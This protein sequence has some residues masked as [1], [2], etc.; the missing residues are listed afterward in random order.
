[1]SGVKSDRLCVQLRHYPF[2]GLFRHDTCIH[3]AIIYTPKTSKYYI[4]CLI[5]SCHP[6]HSIKFHNKDGSHAS[7]PKSPIDLSSPLC[8]ALSSHLSISHGCLTPKRTRTYIT[9][10]PRAIYHSSIRHSPSSNLFSHPILHLPV[11]IDITARLAKYA[12]SMRAAD[13]TR[14]V[15][16]MSGGEFVICV[17]GDP[18]VGGVGM[19]PG[20]G[21]GEVEEDGEEAGS[22]SCDQPCRA[23]NIQPCRCMDLASS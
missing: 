17:F 18:G 14:F 8:L 9:I 15:D 16:Y 10:D 20:G 1:M 23:C 21:G 2:F 12:P 22:A 4:L 3:F 11:I 19:G 6:H 13:S 5:Y 7:T